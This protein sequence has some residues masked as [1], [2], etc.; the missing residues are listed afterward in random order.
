MK[1]EVNA[2]LDPPDGGSN[3]IG[4]WTSVLRSDYQWRLGPVAISPRYK[5]MMR[6]RSDGDGRVHPISELFSYPMVLS[7]YEL[8]EWTSLK[9]GIQGFPG[10]PSLYRNLEDK[11][12]DFDSKNYL[13]MLS[14][15]FEHAGYDL[16]LNAGYEITRRRMRDRRREF[17]DVDYELFFIR[18]VV[19]LEPV[20]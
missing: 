1:Y 6:K 14:N 12:Q 3:R 19:G 10:L 15:R 9:G 11:D 16:A 4:L 5:F 8:T 13:F 20:L 18:M 7:E 17:E 2:Q